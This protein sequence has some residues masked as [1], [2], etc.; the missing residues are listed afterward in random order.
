MAQPRT[1]LGSLPTRGAT[2]AAPASH[3]SQTILQTEHNPETPSATLR[4]RGE[5]SEGRRIQWA[6]DVI[7]NEHMG[8][9]SSKVCCIYHGPHEPGDSSSDSSSSDSDSEP[10]LSKAKKAGGSGKKGRGRKHDH[11]DKDGK[12]GGE[13]SGKGKERRPSPNA[14]E[15]QPKPKAKKEG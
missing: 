7:D 5:P 11:D 9:K 8:K 6:E 15:R 12:D 3:G 14:Y 1:T 13:G 4:L 10:D 2:A